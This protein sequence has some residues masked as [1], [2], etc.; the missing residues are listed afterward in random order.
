MSGKRYIEE[1]KIEAGRQVSERGCPVTEVPSRLGVTAHN[2][3]RA[4]HPK[5]GRRVLCQEGCP[6]FNAS[7]C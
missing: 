1:F 5:K 6:H 7:D 2:D 4:R 3:G